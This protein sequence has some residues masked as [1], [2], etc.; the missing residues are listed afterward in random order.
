MRPGV[1]EALRLPMQLGSMSSYFVLVEDGMPDRS[2]PL[3]V[4]A[5]SSDKVLNPIDVLGLR[6]SRLGVC[7]CRRPSA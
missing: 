1:R 6:I 7:G 3:A 2:C 4:A 5:A